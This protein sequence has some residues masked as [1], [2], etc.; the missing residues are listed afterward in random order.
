MVGNGNTIN[1]MKS[2]DNLRRT[3]LKLPVGSR[4]QYREITISDKAK[5]H[6]GNIGIGMLQGHNYDYIEA[7]G[8]KVKNGDYDGLNSLIDELG[9]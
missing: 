8:G 3:T 9:R 2:R 1:P 6:N 4:H 5:V 7:N